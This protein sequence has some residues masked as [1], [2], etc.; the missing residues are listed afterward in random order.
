MA[1]PRPELNKEC[2][3]KYY[4]SK[5]SK[6][7]SIFSIELL[8]IVSDNGVAKPTLSNV[9]AEIYLDNLQDAQT[10]SGE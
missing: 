8:A 9:I 6:F 1:S 2:Q 4:P 3:K 7:R 10:K 5:F